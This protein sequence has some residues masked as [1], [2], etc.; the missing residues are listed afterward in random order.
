LAINLALGGVGSEDAS[1]YRVK[2]QAHKNR[3]N[4]G[5]SE[6]GEPLQRA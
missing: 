3:W 4:H 1:H 5:H 2:Q 6:I